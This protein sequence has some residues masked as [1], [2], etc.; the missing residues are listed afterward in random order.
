MLRRALIAATPA[1]LLAVAVCLFF[2]NKAYTIDDAT[3]LLAAEHMLVD[4]LHPFAFDLVFNG[5]PTRAST[6]VTGPV[7][8]TLLI[9]A[10]L[11]G[12][13]EWVAHGVMLLLF[14]V[15]LVSS[16]ALS[17]RLGTSAEAAAW[18]SV[19]VATSAA[20]LVMATTS[21]PDVPAMTFGALGAERLLAFR[22]DR[23]VLTGIVAAVALALA[24]LS[25]THLILLFV[26][27]TVLLLAPWPATL[28]AARVVLLSRPFWVN[29]LPLVSAVVLVWA[30]TVLTRDPQTGMNFVSSIRHNLQWP[31]LRINVS[32]VPAQ[33][34]LAFPLGVA[35]S[36][37]CGRHMLGSRSCWLGAVI[38]VALA[39][40]VPTANG[41][42]QRTWWQAPTTA[43][44]MA[45]LVD[46]A[47]DAWRRRD[48]VQL[49][50]WAW[51]LIAWP[52][53][54]YYQLP[55]KY[56]VP[57]APAM[58]LIVVR[59]AEHRVRPIVA[60]CVLVV[61]AILS[62][63]LGVAIAHA[64][65]ALSDVGRIGGRLAA[66]YVKRGER[67]WYDGGWSFSWYARR[68][69]ARPMSTA[70]PFP[71]SGDVVIAGL[72]SHLVT[73]RCPSKELLQERV[74]DR[75]GGRI[76]DGAAGFY[77]NT[78][79]YGPL[80]WIWRRDRALLSSAIGSRITVWRIGECR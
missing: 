8:P 14:V 31:L 54:V 59:Q 19:L 12:G 7:M 3:F 5:I 76:Q 47:V 27:L 79:G 17:L 48:A 24:V 51:L 35:W 64:D 37:L 78:L 68:A 33:W 22:S 43:L 56:L 15:G 13:S 60:R 1:T 36:G 23:R 16:A 4:P 20:V 2:A 38:G 57:S 74:F 39:I 21:M 26:P 25:R 44:G 46:I 55:P 32:Q 66:D 40:L 30:V 41:Q 42:W 72:L 63:A 6:N 45:V 49:A 58:A 71:A 67:T 50:L 10:I 70:P 29:V 73:E 52:A 61:S 28:S 69:G 77:T 53:A 34:V 62:L 65:A 80:P 11:A 9:P 75:P 18:V